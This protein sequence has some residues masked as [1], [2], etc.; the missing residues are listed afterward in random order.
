[1]IAFGLR[2]YRQ[3]TEL[4]YQVRY[5]PLIALILDVNTLKFTPC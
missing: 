1:M 3:G 5:Q 4:M 2:L